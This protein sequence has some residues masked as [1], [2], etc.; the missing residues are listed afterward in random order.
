M[1]CV[2]YHEG[3]LDATKTTNPKIEIYTKHEKS[4]L[5]F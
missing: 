3:A 4:F 2:L 1:D 5:I